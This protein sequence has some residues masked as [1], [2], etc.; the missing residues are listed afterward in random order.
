MDD[1][2]Q[3]KVSAMILQFAAP[4]LDL[5][6]AGASDVEVL[7]SLMMMVEMCWNLPVFETTDP[8]AYVQFKKGFE[9]VTQDVPPEIAA[10][11]EQL[12]LDRRTRYGHIPLL[13]HVRVEEAGPGKASLVTE[14]RMPATAPHFD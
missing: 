13:V 6:R 7:R 12:L 14:A 9:T 5:D 4:L 8:D 10:V 3:R 1:P 11:L 2:S